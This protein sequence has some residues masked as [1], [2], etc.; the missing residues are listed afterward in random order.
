MNESSELLSNAPPPPPEPTPP[1][2]AQPVANK[3]AKSTVLYQSETTTLRRSERKIKRSIFSTYRREMR[4]D[5][6]LELDMLGSDS[7]EEV[8]IISR[9]KAPSHVASVEDASRKNENRHPNNERFV[10]ETKVN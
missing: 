5:K 1:S 2:V 6:K 10:P 4:K 9:K 8:K 7:D 3:E